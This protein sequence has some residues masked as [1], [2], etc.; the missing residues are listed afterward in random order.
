MDTYFAP[1]GRSTPDELDRQVW[2]TS[3]SPVVAA[4]LHSVSGMLAILNDKRQVLAV[5]DTLLRELGFDDA[6]QAL[7][8]RPGEALECVHAR[9]EPAGCGTTKFCSTCGAA[10]AMVTSLASDAP[11]ERI[12]A[13]SARRNGRHVD[14]CLLVRAAPLQI[15]HER[16]L[17]LFLRDIT[18]Q[19]QR[20]ALERVFL[21]D[22]GN[23]LSGLT[24]AASLLSA[25]DVDPEVVALVRSS[26]LRLGREVALQRSLLKTDNDM[27]E[28]AP[29]RTTAERILGDL[30]RLFAAH[31]VASG[32]TLAFNLPPYDVPMHVDVSLLLRVLANMVTNAFEAS[33]AGDRVQVAVEQAHGRVSFSV[34]NRQPIDERVAL[35]IFQR[36]FTTK[37]GE[38]RGLGTYSMKLIGERYLGGEVTFSSTPQ[39]GTV[40][41]V[42]IPVPQAVE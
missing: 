13:L 7:G 41:T 9:D 19:W 1:P 2:I 3:N 6:G 10:I 24:T 14:T 16:L 42:S 21:H 25:G 29:E 38:G 35:R 34:W 22:I 30:Q 5:N 11:A 28:L 17:L 31:P 23:M 18:R 33:G 27:Y 39:R 37:E 32:K 4:L 36:N 12:C 26:A 20:A 40:F 15:D 8:L